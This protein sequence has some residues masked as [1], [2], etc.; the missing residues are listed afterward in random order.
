MKQP[1]LF[2][3]VVFSLATLSEDANSQVTC[4]SFRVVG[5][6]N[7]VIQWCPEGRDVYGGEVQRRSETGTFQTLP[8]SFCPSN[9]PPLV[10]CVYADVNVPGGVWYYRIRMIALDGMSTYSDSL[11]VII[12]ISQTDYVIITPPAYVS[13]MQPLAAFRTSHNSFSVKIV[14]TDLIYSQ[15]GQGAPPDSAIR[16]F[17]TFALTWW[18]NPKPQYFLLSGNVNSIPSHKEPSIGYADSIIV[19]QWFV[20]GVPDTASIRRPAASIGRF[21][22][23]NAT[24]LSNMVAKTVAYESAPES[25]WAR[26]AIGVADAGISLG[27][28]TFFEAYARQF[29]ISLSP[30]W[31]DTLSVHVRPSS[32]HHLTRRQFF[33]TINEGAAITILVGRAN[34]YRF[35]VPSYFTTWDVDSLENGLR[36]PFW[37]IKNHQRFERNDT[38]PTVVNL[39]GSNNKG[40]IATFAPTDLSYATS[41]G[42]FLNYVFQK[43][44]AHPNEPIG[45]S[46]LAAK[47]N[48]RDLPQYT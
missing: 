45:K 33:N 6:N 42:L 34:E 38:L 37:I 27:E 10:G 5:G 17:V 14:T 43:M 44:T 28:A 8:G 35:G 18:E 15:F 47:R 48:Y 9:P 30:V 7:V 39:L 4:L 26:R 46:I 12:D 24:Q 11:V 23:W 22:A 16:R 41:S 21:P 40:G 1:L 25:A 13:I 32:P 20:E 3:A 2:L 19:D 36:L 31:H 29:M